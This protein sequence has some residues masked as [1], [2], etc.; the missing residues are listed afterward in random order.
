[1]PPDSKSTSFFDSQKFCGIIFTM[2]K[3]IDKLSLT[4]IGKY[5]LE[6]LSESEACIMADASNDELTSLKEKNQ[7]IREFIEKSKVQFKYSHL[8]EMQTKR[9]DKTSQWLLE[10][11][12]PEDFATGRSKVSTTINVIQTIIQQIQKDDSPQ[13]IVRSRE[14]R[15]NTNPESE[16]ISGPRPGFLEILQ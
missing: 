2:S 6:G 8:Q 11:L 14:D 12:R 10:R 7:N 1:M 15:F 16:K 4:L 9:S 13:L 5:I 3:P